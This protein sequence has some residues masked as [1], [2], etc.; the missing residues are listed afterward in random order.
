MFGLLM[1][2]DPVV[3]VNSK[4]EQQ[5]VTDKILSIMSKIYLENSII[6]R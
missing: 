2:F 1:I 5:L 4:R 6:C 3:H